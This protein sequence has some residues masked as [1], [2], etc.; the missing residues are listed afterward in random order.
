MHIG[1]DLGFAVGRKGQLPDKSLVLPEDFVGV[2]FEF[3]NVTHPIN[4]NLDWAGLIEEKEDGSLRNHGR[5]FVF[6]TPLFGKDV[7]DVIR[8]MCAEATAKKYAVSLRTGLHIHID[9]RDISYDQ[10]HWWIVLNAL[11]EPALYTWVGD[12]RDENVFC[13]PW[14]STQGIIPILRKIYSAKGERLGVAA[15][16]LRQ[17][18][19]SGFNLDTLSRFGSIEYRQLKNTMDADRIIQWL[20]ILLRFKKL[21]G[22][23]A[24]QGTP[25]AEFLSS[26]YVTQES[27]WEVLLLDQYKDLYYPDFIKDIKKKG[28]PTALDIIRSPFAVVPSMPN[29]KN[30]AVEKFLAGK[31]KGKAPTPVEW[32]EDVGAPIPAPPA[33]PNRVEGAGVG[34]AAAVAGYQVRFNRL[35]DYI[36]AGYP[37]ADTAR[38]RAQGF[39]TRATLKRRLQDIEANILARQRRLLPDRTRAEIRLSIENYTRAIGGLSEIFD[40]FKTD[41]Q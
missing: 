35:L 2:E 8:G 16:E 10:L 37:G 29:K 22:E 25:I 18:K 38:F 41:I 21:S 23:L 14:H 15:S 40:E 39:N 26:A 11:L 5:E 17:R 7:T 31:I 12:G 28:I 6:T 19:Y 33:P 1:K 32:D 36:E 9:A 4:K 13:L 27:H 30:E 34:V 24:Q 20:N 3:E